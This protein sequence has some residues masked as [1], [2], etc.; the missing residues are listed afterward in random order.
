MQENSKIELE[1]ERKW[2]L[3]NNPF[4]YDDYDRDYKHNPDHIYLIDQYYILHEGTNK[5]L[6]ISKETDKLGHV[7]NTEIILIHKKSISPGVNEEYHYEIS[8]DEAYDLINE[9]RWTARKI[10]KTRTVKKFDGFKVE[11]DSFH[12]MDLTMMEIELPSLDYNVEVPGWL[13]QSILMEVTGDPR[14]NNFNLTET[15]VDEQEN[16]IKTIMGGDRNKHIKI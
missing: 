4:K 6:R 5:R 14:F 12:N 7:I 9:Q 1:I 2:I 8:E 10:S 15:P 13:Y 3:R 11:V 16:F